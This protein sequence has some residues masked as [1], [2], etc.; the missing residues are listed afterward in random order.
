MSDNFEFFSHIIQ[1]ILTQRELYVLD[2]QMSSPIRFP[3]FS[4]FCGIS[5]TFVLMDTLDK[6]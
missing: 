3:W 6:S 5:G 4:V 1:E 2:E